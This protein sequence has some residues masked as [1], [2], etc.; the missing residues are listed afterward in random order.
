VAP[1]QVVAMLNRFL[2]V[3]ADIVERF[4]G[5]IDKYVGD[6]LMAVFHGD[7]GPPRAVQAAIAMVAAVE[8]AREAGETLA[9]GAGISTGEVVHGPIGST[10]RMDFTVIGDVV[11]IGARLCSAAQ[12]SEVII[13]A[14]VREAM[15][16]LPDVE[17]EALE[18]L[19]LK[20]KRQPFAVYRVRSAR[21]E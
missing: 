3:Q 19:Q 7:D 11:N 4:Q 10:E 21:R 5:D 8:G 16:D 1:E 6:E 14:A 13:S 15:G 9:V 17:L 18:P 2:Q 20:G 12:P